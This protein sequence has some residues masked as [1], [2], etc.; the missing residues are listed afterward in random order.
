MFG[1]EADEFL[2]LSAWARGSA[3]QGARRDAFF[4]FLLIFNILLLATV[5]VLVG[6]AVVRTY[7]P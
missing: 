2:D 7:F 1:P 3:G 6:G 4:W 5:G